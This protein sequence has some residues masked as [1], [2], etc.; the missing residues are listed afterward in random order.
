MNHALVFTPDGSGRCLFTEAI[1]LSRIG[2]LSLRRATRIEFDNQAQY[3]R[4]YLARGRLAL[5]NS[6]SRQQCLEWERQ[7][8]E[9]Q[10]DQK[11]EL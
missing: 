3:W 8:L 4:V 5:F 11:H 6:P 7:Y 1:D 10:E 2:S 9:Q